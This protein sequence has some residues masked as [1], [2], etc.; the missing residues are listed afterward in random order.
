MVAPVSVGIF[1]YI[2]TIKLDMGLKGASLAVFFTNFL[3]ALIVN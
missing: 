3:V 2:L 1:S